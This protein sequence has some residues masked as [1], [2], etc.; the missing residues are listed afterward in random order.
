MSSI[1]AHSSSSMF[2]FTLLLSMLTLFITVML[3]ALTLLP[4]QSSDAKIRELQ[5]RADQT[6]QRQNT[7][8]NFFTTALKNP[9][10]LQRLFTQV[11][12]GGV[13]R[14]TAPRTGVSCLE[15]LELGRQVGQRRCTAHVCT[16]LEG[17]G[18]G[19]QRWCSRMDSCSLIHI[20]H[21]TQE[22]FE[23]VVF[24][25]PCSLAPCSAACQAAGGR[26]GCSSGGRRPGAG[27]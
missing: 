8:I 22:M 25:T 16:S 1:N 9:A 19:N 18:P 17:G 14:I 26:R 13:Q 3:V 21:V 7:I 11:Q 10:M 4:C 12:A 5:Q 15:G 6:E 20:L 23:S 2:H 27:P 24:S